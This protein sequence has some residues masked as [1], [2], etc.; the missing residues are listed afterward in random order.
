ME[1]A[2]IGT[3]AAST[4]TRHIHTIGCIQLA[5]TATATS[6][7]FPAHMDASPAHPAAQPPVGVAAAT[8]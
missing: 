6:A 1:A 8:I 7:V 2:G 3:L 5:L 4:T